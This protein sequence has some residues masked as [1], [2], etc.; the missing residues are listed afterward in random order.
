MTEARHP[1]GMTRRSLLAGAAAGA[2]WLAIPKR[3][4]AASRAIGD[5]D[6]AHGVAAGD[7]STHSISLW[8]RVSGLEGDGVV[9]LE[10][11][12][13]ADFRHVVHHRRA[14]APA[15]RDF[16][17]HH[18]LNHEPV[19]RPG[20][21]YFYRFF[22]RAS[23]SP[24][25]RFRT[26]RPADSREPLRI[27]FW[28]CQ[29][30]QSGHYAAHA[31][32]AADDSLDLVVGLGDY[33]YEAASDPGPRQD[34]IGPDASAQTLDEYR[35]KYRLYKSD[36]SLRAMHHAHAYSG[37]W[38]DHEVESSYY[39]HNPGNA[40]GRGRRVTFHQR[41]ANGQRAFLEYMPFRR[42]HHDPARI[43]RRIRVGANA[44]LFLCDLHQYAGALPCTGNPMAGPTTLGPCPER[45]EAGR[46]LLGDAQR[47][48]LKRGL[49]GSSARWKLIANSMM[50][51][52]LDY[53]PGN[54]FNYS[55]WDGWPVE[56][57]ELMRHI[58]DRGIDDVVVVSG[59]IHTFFAGQVTTT[60]DITG[61]PAA[62]ELIASSISSHGIPEGL[63]GVTGLPPGLLAGVTTNL[64]LINPHIRYNEQTRRGYAVLECH[65][66]EL[67]AEFRAVANQNDPASAVS[68]LKRFRVASGTPDVQVL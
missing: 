4:R 62:V 17:V 53:A 44:E 23:D 35:A 56:R 32:I 11:A 15:A 52:G 60:G 40:Q 51:M 58:L 31:D 47:A 34:T 33:I 42:N 55:Q 68:T 57:R 8:T 13:D 28:S 59:D 37:V 48:W 6:F 46:S 26:L 10:I 50:M 54:S 45:D 36:A 66:G 16:T 14:G 64:P 67:L 61:T 27:A 39:G 9:G 18:R 29:N 41:R 7:P 20:E 43:Y 24:V 49:A 22:T 2:G 25:G 21:Q 5:G 12:R 19:L 30:W 3:A 63:A 65:P 1:A 38:D